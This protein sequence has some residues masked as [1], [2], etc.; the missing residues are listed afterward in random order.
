MILCWFL[1]GMNNSIRTNI[2][3]V[4]LMEM[5]PKKWRTGVTSGLFIF[6]TFIYVLATFYF[7]KISVHWQGIVIIGYVC[8][9]IC[10]GTMFLLPESPQYLIKKGKLDQAREALE[11]VAKWNKK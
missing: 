9:V 7:W 2:G 5:M 6:E 3:Y 1:Q 4:Y 11:K 10:V 8:Q